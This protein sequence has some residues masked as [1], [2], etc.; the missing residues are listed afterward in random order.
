MSPEWV[1]DPELLRLL[2]FK[3]PPTSPWLAKLYPLKDEPGK[4]ARITDNKTYSSI[5]TL[6]SNIRTG[7]LAGVVRGEYEA[8]ALRDEDGIFVLYA[9][10][11]G[12]KDKL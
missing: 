11:I 6:A 7:N 8:K 5:Q 9:R 3:R 1:E 10:Y 4:W 12:E 2:Q